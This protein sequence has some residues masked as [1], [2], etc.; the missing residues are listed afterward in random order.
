M[1][2]RSAWNRGEAKDFVPASSLAEGVPPLR[3]APVGRSGLSPEWT[4]TPVGG[5]DKVPT[6]VALLGSQKGLNVAVLIDIQKKDQQTIEDLYKRKLLKKQNV[7][8]FADFVSSAEADIEDMFDPAFYLELVSGEFALA[9][10]PIVV[11]DLTGKQPRILVR[12]EEYFSASPLQDAVFSHYRPAR[13]FMENVEALNTHISG[14]TL[15]RFEEAFT[16]LN[17]LLKPSRKAR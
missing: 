8:T 5:A 7:M 4:I 2:G 13:Y 1:G 10:K 6:F 16:S 14:D 11:S 12:L 3:S 17:A 15:D 9:D